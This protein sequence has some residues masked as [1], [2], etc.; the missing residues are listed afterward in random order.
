MSLRR[1]WQICGWCTRQGGR[2]FLWGTWLVLLALLGVQ[3]AILSSRKIDIPAPLRRTLDERLAAH[4]LR[5][6][7]A[8]GAFDLSGHVLLEEVRAGPL[9]SP[10][11]LATAGT[12]YL[13]IRPWALFHGSV[14]VAEVRVSGLDLD[15]PA[16][17]S[18]SGRDVPLARGLD[19]AFR[20]RGDGG[21]LSWFSGYIGPVA[22]SASGG[23]R[24]AALRQIPPGQRQQP[25]PAFV[26]AARRAEPVLARLAALDSPDLDLRL[27]PAPGRI[28]DAA[29]E[30]H[31]AGADLS[32]LGYDLPVR[33]GAI[34]LA[35]TLPLGGP[36]PALASATLTAADLMLPPDIGARDA[37]LSLQGTIGAGAP[38]LDLRRAALQLSGLRWRDLAI[39]SL[40][41]S[42]DLPEANRIRAA[43][44]LQLAGSPWSLQADVFPQRGAGT[45]QLDGFV[46]NDSL[47]LAGKI[48][49]R[50]LRE[51]LDPAVPA[52]LHASAAFDP[53]WKPARASGRLHSGLVRV[54]RV[55]RPLVIL[56]ETAADFSWDGLRVLCESLVL[57]QGESLALG[58]YEM[59]TA[60]RDFRFLLT[61][62]LRPMGI[63]GWFHAW[64]TNFWDD[65][66]FTGSIPQADVDVR[67]RW[68]DLTKTTV[69]VQAAGAR[70]GLRG[71][72]F[73]R[74]DTRLFIRPHWFDIL[75]FDV[76]HEGHGA[77][78]SFA[79][80]LEGPKDDWMRME[81]DVKSDLPLDKIGRLFKTEAGRL[82]EPYRFDNPPS[83]HILGHVAS[84]AAPAGKTE[85]IDIVL[86]STGT[87][88]Y[89]G[90][91]LSDLSARAGIRDSVI[92]LPEIAAGF[93][94][95]KV[96]GRATVRGEEPA[97]RLAF[98]ISLRSASLGAVI[99]SLPSSSKTGTAG[100]TAES[101]A[102]R[103]RLAQGVLDFTLKA[104]G[105]Y[106]D[107]HSF[108]GSGR[109]GISGT[110]LAQ[111]N[112]FGPLSEALSKTIFNLGSFSLNTLEAPFELAG[113]RV[114][115]DELR[116]T[117][118]SALLLASGDY[119][120]KDGELAF[121]V[122]VHP[123]DQSDSLVGTAVG[124]VLSPL[125]HVLKVKLQGTLEKPSW[126]FA[127]G[128]S[129]ILSTLA[130][131]EKNR[132]QEKEPP[133]AETSR[134]AP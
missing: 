83:L 27:S 131:P 129:R 13:R 86:A 132:P 95:G 30:F 127:Y 36:M 119:G 87:A 110:E 38:G 113:D 51:I 62:R 44:S 50:D 115:F 75:H 134:P 107:P 103:A 14:E 28:A 85:H 25:L 111:L 2:L 48:A 93:A 96:A 32:R 18:L 128:P 46:D 42:A 57:R 73:D 133:Q 22:V 55:D 64:W 33:T 123:F 61:G 91:P 124:Y 105:A 59:D 47:D 112:L 24:L 122:R 89:H 45:V 79:R 76:A 10:Y 41:A 70:T 78:G 106:A 37:V 3:V 99:Q 56:D 69:F 40:S 92:D 77:R 34:R 125:S 16:P 101:R 63:A 88:H 5:L 81:F 9:A 52:L 66:D 84:A 6:D 58:S 15:L 94:G 102:R 116:I 21:D 35:T 60:T 120:L 12:V 130:G 39:P 126:I 117:G 82:I 108:Q 98:D 1:T 4:G 121:D 118:P 29:V 114:H 26:G 104:E 43:V 53:G 68:G 67:G 20:P 72:P 100:E 7:F 8:R 17:L 11:S 90:F 31:A 49:G 65:F 19:F 74:V 23:L 54:G 109:G 97:R 80:E 71:E